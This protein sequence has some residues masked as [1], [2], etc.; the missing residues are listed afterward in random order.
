MWT[1]GRIEVIA[2]CKDKNLNEI[3]NILY[4]R[5]SYGAYKRD[6][7]FNNRTYSNDVLDVYI[8]DGFVLLHLRYGLTPFLVRSTVVKDLSFIIISVFFIWGRENRM[9][10]ANGK[11]LAKAWAKD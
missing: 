11:H 2:V 5:F 9:K 3:N 7:S 1:L 10:Q 8:A 4:I 6:K